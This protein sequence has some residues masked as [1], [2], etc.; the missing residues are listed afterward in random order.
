VI[1]SVA[2]DQTEPISG[3]FSR[4]NIL[5]MKGTDLRVTSIGSWA[6]TPSREKG[7]GWPG[8]TSSQSRDLSL[9]I[10]GYPCEAAQTS[11]PED[12][13]SMLVGTNVRV[14][15]SKRNRPSLAHKEPRAR[16]RLPAVAHP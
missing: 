16:Y 1:K 3:R 7:R 15:S 10:V 5:E 9:T 14:G 6:A 13:M 12:V 8:T 4:F 2:E 11:L